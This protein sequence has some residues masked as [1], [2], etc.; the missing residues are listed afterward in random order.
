MREVRVEE[1]KLQ[2]A[3][4]K[5]NVRERVEE[6]V[7]VGARVVEDRR[8]DR[9]PVRPTPGRRVVGPVVGGAVNQ[10]RQVAPAEPPVE[11][12]EYPVRRVR[13]V[14]NVPHLERPHQLRFDL[15]EP[16][17]TE[18]GR[19]VRTRRVRLGHRHMR[20]HGAIDEAPILDIGAH[21]HLAER[22]RV[23]L[24]ARHLRPEA[25]ARDSARRADEAVDVGGRELVVFDVGLGVVERGE[26]VGRGP[27]RTVADVYEAHRGP[28]HGAKLR[29]HVALKDGLPTPLH[30]RVTMAFVLDAAG[31][32]GVAG[33]GRH[34]SGHRG[35]HGVILSDP[36]ELRLILPTGHKLERVP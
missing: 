11:R 9:R 16:E 18:Q 4:I 21:P 7:P 25:R 33:G 13:G 10:A 22:E 14:A 31:L 32:V 20:R 17:L 23:R 34:R 1:P 12:L 27:Q 36:Q 24:E 8:D 3:G 35:I 29:L 28:A 19:H 26:L 5:L 6:P 2:R 15:T 30:H